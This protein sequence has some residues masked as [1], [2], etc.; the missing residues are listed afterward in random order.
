MANP[1]LQNAA[2]HLSKRRGR[3]GNFGRDVTVGQTLSPT[4]RINASAVAETPD[5]EHKDTL[6]HSGE[7]P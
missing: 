6:R 7:I 1:A 4:A 2:D 5:V 3:L